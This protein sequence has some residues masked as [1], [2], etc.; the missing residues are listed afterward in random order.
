MGLTVCVPQDVERLDRVLVQLEVVPQDL[1]QHVFTV[2]RHPGTR[3]LTRERESERER[4]RE[5]P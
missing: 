3:D 1:D 5:T 2:L 4:E